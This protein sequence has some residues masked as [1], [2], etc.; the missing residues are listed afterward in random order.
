MRI[1]TRSTPKGIVA[2][3]YYVLDHYD[4]P[5]GSFNFQTDGNTSDIDLGYTLETIKESTELEFGVRE[6]E[7]T[8]QDYSRYDTPLTLWFR[9]SPSW[10]LQSGG[11]DLWTRRAISNPNIGLNNV[12]VTYPKTHEELMNEAV[13]E[14]MD[15]NEVDSLLNLLETQQLQSSLKGIFSFLKRLLMLKGAKR[16]RIYFNQ[17]G[18]KA[19]GR[20]DAPFVNLRDIANLHLGWSFGFAP[21]IDDL[22]KISRALPKLRKDLAKLARNSTKPYTVTRRCEGEVSFNPTGTSGYGSSPT[23]KWTEEL[24][25]LVPPV[26]IAGVRG[27]RTIEYNLEEFQQLDYLIS[28]FIATGPVTLVWERV[29]FSFVIDWFIDLTGLLEKLDNT[30]ASR[31]KVIDRSWSSDKHEVTLYCICNEDDNEPTPYD[32]EPIA[33][34]VTKYYHRKPAVADHTVSSSGR[35]GKKQ[36]GLSLSLFYQ[37]VANLRSRM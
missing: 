18:Q 20:I 10:R 12:L 21:L 19:T 23:G 8:Y 7:H 32:G 26:R 13:R 35:F 28:R 15:S 1:R 3:H 5:S 22:R 9:E 29:P 11:I 25:I 2:S 31:G 33:S 4:H 17:K 30:L 36:A 16:Q 34:M 27:R 14:F 37:M 6:V 24:K